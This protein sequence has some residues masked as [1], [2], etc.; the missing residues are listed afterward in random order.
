MRLFRS[1]KK[2]A[3]RSD[4]RLPKRSQKVSRR[5]VPEAE[6]ESQQR[7]FFPLF[8]WSVFVATLVYTA[9]FSPFLTIQ[10][11]SVQGGSQ[12]T[13]R[14]LEAFLYRRTENP[15]WFV[16]PSR[17]LFFFSEDRLEREA[18]L[19]FP[20]LETVKVRTR[21]PHDALLSVAEREALVL[22]CSGG[23]CYVATEDGHLEEGSLADERL[24][25]DIPVYR[26]IDESALPVEM[27]ERV[28]EVPVAARIAEYVRALPE[29][30]GIQVLPEI[31]TPS[32][33]AREARFRTEDGFEFY[34]NLETDPEEAFQALELFFAQEVP[35]EEIGALR[36]IDLRTP[37]RIYYAR[38]NAPQEEESGGDNADDKSGEGD[39]N[40]KDKENTKDKD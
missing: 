15:I 2:K 25:R 20:H 14:E 17:N 16:F 27:G 8:L 23:P 18:L 35:R 40:E 32:R 12:E 38:K 36:Y 34:A 39:G 26:V 37:N 21:F 24:K 31:K 5:A 1:K 3:F 29:R 28:L 13:A 33:F 7:H 9:F 4:T 6:T 22:W 19:E 30:F 11:V 10:S